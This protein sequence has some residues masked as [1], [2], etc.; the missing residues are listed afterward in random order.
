MINVLEITIPVKPRVKERP[1]FGRGKVYTTKRTSDFEKHIK[2]ECC[3][4]G[5]K[6]I[7]GFVKLTLVVSGKLRGDVDNYLKAVGDALNGVA[8]S[9]DKNVVWIDAKKER[10]EPFVYIRVE[11]I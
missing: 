10:G 9:D 3:L 7:E 8:Y 11:E 4:A 5:F 1:R 6:P 2:Q